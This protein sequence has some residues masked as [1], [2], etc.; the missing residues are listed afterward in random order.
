MCSSD[1]TTNKY[2]L[3]ERTAKARMITAQEAGS[4]GCK[5]QTHGVGP[6]WMRNFLSGSASNGGTSAG[7]VNGYWMMSAHYAYNGSA[8]KIISSGSIDYNN[9][10]TDTSFGA[11]AVVVIDK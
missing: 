5:W 3:E 6:V 8:I 4:V 2:T 7:T 11:R 10:T 1:L 9:N